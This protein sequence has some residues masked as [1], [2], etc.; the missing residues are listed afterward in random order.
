M[1]VIPIHYQETNAEIY[2]RIANSVASK[3]GCVV[4]YNFCGGCK[5]VEFLG[6]ESNKHRIAAEIQNLFRM[7]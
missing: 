7:P 5:K 1:S 4:K 2:A 6:D 3:Y